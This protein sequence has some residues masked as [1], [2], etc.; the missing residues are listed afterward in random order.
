MAGGWQAMSWRR[1][2]RL[3]L[4]DARVQAEGSLLERDWASRA[5]GLARIAARSI[6]LRPW[7]GHHILGQTFNQ[8]SFICFSGAFVVK[9]SLKDASPG[10]RI[11][12]P[13]LIHCRPGNNF[14]ISL[15]R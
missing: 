14:A 6:R 7:T 13:A 11:A 4:F 15:R 12:S 8:P 5:P 3:A 2:D 9:R 10:F 1:L